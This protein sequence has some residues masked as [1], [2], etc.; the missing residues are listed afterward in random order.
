MSRI[1]CEL[2]IDLPCETGSAWNIPVGRLLY[3]RRALK[4]GVR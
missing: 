2:T 4:N 3:L 1:Q